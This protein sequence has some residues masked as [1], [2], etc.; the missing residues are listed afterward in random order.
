MT[1][2]LLAA[3]AAIL[4][5][6]AG[7]SSDDSEPT[8]TPTPESTTSSSSVTSSPAFSDVPEPEP[9]TEDTQAPAPAPEAAIPAPAPAP[10]APTFVRCFLADGTALM[11]DGTTTYMDSCHEFAGG[12][13]RLAD[14]TSIYD[15]HPG[16]A[17]TKAPEVEAEKQ[18][19]HAWWAE[20]IAA[21]TPDFCR[22]NDPWQ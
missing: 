7:C 11:S 18:A 12:P 20:C 2:A 5:A 21:N 9:T 14:G 22:A 6:A 15:N 16:L 17:P 10:A 19:G 3:A 1:R 8:S 4:L 13:P